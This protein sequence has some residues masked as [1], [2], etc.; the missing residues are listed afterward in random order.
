MIRKEIKKCK[1]L[2]FLNNNI[3]FYEKIL[4]FIKIKYE[5]E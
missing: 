5:L 4:C 3:N 1:D 2:Q